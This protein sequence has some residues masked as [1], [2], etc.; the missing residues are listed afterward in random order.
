MCSSCRLYGKYKDNMSFTG[1]LIPFDFDIVSADIS[2]I[3]P[4]YS[5]IIFTYTIR[6]TIDNENSGLSQDRTQKKQCCGSE[7]GVRDQVFFNTGSGIRI[8]DEGKTDPEP[9]SGTNMLDHIFESLEKYLNSLMRIRIRNPGRKI[10]IWDSGGKNSDTGSGN[11][12]HWEYEK[13]LKYPFPRYF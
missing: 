4:L 9:G 12:Q 13:I 11:S 8:R 10:Q 6:T 7:S 3:E 5:C 1:S 2:C